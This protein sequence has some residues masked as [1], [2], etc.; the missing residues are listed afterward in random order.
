M[1]WKD[2]FSSST[3]G[4]QSVPNLLSP[5]LTK[6]QSFLQ[7]L[8]GWNKLDAYSSRNMR[9]SSVYRTAH[10]LL[11][12]RYQKDGLN[13]NLEHDEQIQAYFCGKPC[14]VFELGMGRTDLLILLLCSCLPQ[15]LYHI[16]LRLLQQGQDLGEWETSREK[17]SIFGCIHMEGSLLILGV[18]KFK[19]VFHAYV[20]TKT[21]FLAR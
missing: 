5:Q 9:N 7:K 8:F 2:I 17:V 10:T 18:S 1:G 15:M 19:I 16:C 11:T 21:Y 3:N 4:T 6:F 12:S 13:A 20:H 14:F